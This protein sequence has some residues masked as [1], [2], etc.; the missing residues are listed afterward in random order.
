MNSFA[1]S[2]GLALQKRNGSPVDGAEPAEAG[3]AARQAPP[4]APRMRRYLPLAI[5]TTGLVVVAPAILVNA[6]LPHGSVPA[7]AL[8]AA[9]AVAVSLA[10]A[11]LG[12]ALWKRQPR[13]RDV[14]F[15]ELLLWGWVRRCWTERRLSQAREL[16]ESARKAG[17]LVNIEL[18]LGLSRLLEARDAY[19]HGH[20]QRVAR[21]GV[22]IARAMGL[23]PREIA[24]L[25]T[26]AEVH[27]VGKLYTPREILNSP[28]PLSD[29]D[30]KLVKQH[31]LQGAEMV[32]VVG[33]PEITAI[34]RHHHERIDGGGYPDGLCGAEIP[35]GARIIAVADTFDAI[36]SDRA[37]RSAGSQKLALDVLSAEA[38]TQLDADAVAVFMQ[39]Y[40]ARRSVAW[41]AAGTVVMQRAALAL[42]SLGSNLGAGSLASVSTLVPTLGAVGVLAVSPA[43]FGTSHGA[44]QSSVTAAGPLALVQSLPSPEQ[45]AQPGPE[46][47][48]GVDRAR[49]DASNG[50]RGPIAHVEPRGGAQTGTGGRTASPRAP[51]SDAADSAGAA[52]SSGATPSL[53]G[54]ASEGGTSG[55][56]PTPPAGTSS[57]A[58]VTL[59]VGGGG[60]H[61]PSQPSIPITVPSVSTPTVSAPTVSTPSVS[62]PAIETPSISA[63]GVTVPSVHVPSV[64]V[65]GVTVPSVKLPGL[66]LGG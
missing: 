6:D 7:A 25:R 28:Y 60:A 42:Q 36:T 52:A 29:E 24:K 5:A 59:P 3:P 50:G 48:T 65:P 30:F 27:D 56:S 49:R 47:G 10:L 61:A 1:G 44:R 62:T 20:S 38:G 15:A 19:L 43:L 37:Y 63:A 22:R 12:A 21:H 39:G 58:P 46:A 4:A 53:A 23:S 34:V 2:A 54:S 33:D 26:A 41:Y 35:L 8:S 11:V 40:S 18:L 16:F 14:V 66:K 51:A 57:G 13:S 31:A 32:S 9:V 64:T 17:P 45:G 55:V